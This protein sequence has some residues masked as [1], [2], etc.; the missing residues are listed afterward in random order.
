MKKITFLLSLFVLISLSSVAQFQEVAKLEEYAAFTT[1][2]YDHFGSS[3]AIDGNYIVVGSSGYRDAGSAYVFYNNA[4]TYDTLAILTPSD[5]LNNDEFGFSV[6]I[7]GDVIV[8]GAPYKDNGVAYVFV[9]PAGGW[10]D[11]T[12]TAILSS[13]NNSNDSEFG[14]TVSISGDVIVVGDWYSTVNTVGSGAVYVYEKP[15]EGWASMTQ[16]AQLF[17]SDAIESQEFGTSVSVDGSTIVVGA[18]YS[19]VASVATGAAYVFEKPGAHWMDMTETAKLTSTDGQADDLLGNS[20]AIDA[21]TIIVGA[22]VKDV[23][24]NGAG[25][26]YVFEKAGDSW[27]SATQNAKLNSSTP[28]E[29]QGFGWLIDISDNTILIG[30]VD[31]MAFVF[32]MPE[33]GWSDMTETAVLT[34]S[35]GGL[36]TGFAESLAIANDLIVIGAPYYEKKDP[37]EGAAYL[38]EKPLSGWITANE[39]EM[40]F[41]RA[42]TMLDGIEAGKVVAID[43]NIAVIGSNGLAE[44]L[45]FNGDTWEKLGDLM[46]ATEDDYFGIHLAID[47]DVIVVGTSSNVSKAYVFEKPSDG[48]TTMTQTAILSST[49]WSTADYFGQALDISGTTIIVGAAGDDDNGS[50]SGSAYVYEMPFSGWIDMTETAKLTASDGAVSQYFGK[51]VSISDDVI[52]IGAR[53][54]LSD[55]GAAYVFVKPTDGWVNSTQTAKLVASDRVGGDQF[56]ISVDISGEYA[57]I[58]AYTNDPASIQ[59][60][61][62]AYV[63]EKP[64]SGWVNSTETIKL[65]AD[66]AAAYDL[67]GYS[68]SIDGQNAVIGAYQDDDNGSS[69]GSAYLFNRSTGTW[70]ESGKIAASNGAVNDV[71]GYSVAIS[72]NYILIGAKLAD[73][74][75]FQD[76]GFAYLF[77]APLTW[78]GAVNND[79][80]TAANWDFN[81]EPLFYDDVFIDAGAQPSIT[82]EANCYDIEI[83]PTAQMSIESSALDVNGSLLFGGDFIGSEIIQYRRYIQSDRWEM[84][85]SPLSGQSINRFLSIP[86]NTIVSNSGNYQMKEYDEATD[87]W[88]ANYTSATAGDVELGKGYVVERGS[89]GIVTFEGE[90][91]NAIFN[92]ALTRDGNGWN[93]VSNPFTSAIAATVNGTDS[94][95]YLLNADNLA[96]LDP[97]FAA[98]YI[99]VEDIADPTNL[100]NYKV[101]NNAGSGSLVQDYLQVGQGFFVKAASGGGSFAMTPAMQSH[102]ISIPFKAVENVNWT[103]IELI[104]ESAEGKVSTHLSYNESMTRGLDVSY[105]AGFMNSHPQFAMYS[106]LI[107]DNGENFALQCLPTDFESL[108]VPIGLDAEAGDEINFTAKVANLPSDYIV[109]LED[110]ELGVFTKLEAETDNYTVILDNAS[111]GT[112]R[113]YV[114]TSFKSALGI[115]E[116]GETSFSVV[117]QASSNQLLINGSVEENTTARIYTIQ[118]KLVSTYSLE[119]GS[120]NVLPFAEQS[121]VYVVQIQSVKGVVSQKVNWVN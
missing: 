40:L 47:H 106:K 68:V 44:V 28:V 119:K 88:T 79:W 1:N 43:G 49:D 117:A 111:V 26:V 63:F 62:A 85:G 96:V 61:G 13:T 76:A 100:D 10:E 97:S 54:D 84:I 70:L 78:I 35:D 41:P 57:L 110:R 34:A 71:F 86:G 55:R 46:P 17:P 51:S 81:K 66:D 27:T 15:T 65:V 36:N 115:D 12:E 113:F 20:V 67:F 109:V 101:I 37:S 18:E 42:Y 83:G 19:E 90:P 52:L 33:A 75:E 32:E 25:V 53:G 116:L 8:I 7:S 105:D 98:L 73:Y 120:Q 93:L 6:S 74:L 104:A 48:W 112:G 118:G 29:N 99:W 22:Y 31:N 82:S 14:H 3:I 45:A 2:E 5:G 39:S 94:E 21:N 108:V 87:H 9:K 72:Q 64:I 50:S 92:A 102:Q 4:G 24:Y 114:H 121:G 69:S 30:S 38:Y 16:T 58:G 89:N 23:T 59:N 60:A 95:D 107:D 77:Q 103:G 56:G 80:H 11:M 91:N